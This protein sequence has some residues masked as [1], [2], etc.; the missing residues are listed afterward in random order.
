[1]RYRSRAPRHAG[2]HRSTLRGPRHLHRPAG[3]N[4][5][6][7]AR[8]PSPSAEPIVQSLPNPLPMATIPDFDDPAIDDPEDLQAADVNPRAVLRGHRRLIDDRDVLAV[9]AGHHDVQV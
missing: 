5:V 9:V 2:P 1:T 7:R 8:V 3:S 4:R 6:R